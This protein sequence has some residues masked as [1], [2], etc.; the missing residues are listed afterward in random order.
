MKVE[1][2]RAKTDAELEYDLENIKKDLFGAR[3]RAS[4]G[5]DSNTGR[6]REMR[7]NIARITTILHERSLG[8]RGAATK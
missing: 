4:S 2:I 1:D 5:I 7:R 8:V 3:F 6:I